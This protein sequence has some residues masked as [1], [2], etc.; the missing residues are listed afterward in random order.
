MGYSTQ[1]FSGRRGETEKNH[2]PFRNTDAHPAMKKGPLPIGKQ[3]S[4]RGSI[5]SRQRRW[6]GRLPFIREFNS[7]QQG[8]GLLGGIPQC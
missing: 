5:R 6:I 7:R 2:D 3:A 8:V 4:I 1:G